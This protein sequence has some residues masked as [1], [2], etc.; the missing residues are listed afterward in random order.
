M[1]IGSIDK[2]TT[3][4]N[5][6]ALQRKMEDKSRS[7]RKSFLSVDTGNIIESSSTSESSE[8]SDSDCENSISR[9]FKQLAPISKFPPKSLPNFA[10]AY[11]RNGVSCRAAAMIVT[12]TLDDT[13]GENANIIDKNK[14]TR[15]KQKSRKQYM[16]STKNAN[17][18][19]LYF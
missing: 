5:E 1:C 11:D 17:V 3:K 12:T 14:V 4:R 18:F 2:T 19:S 15:E 9:K 6:K 16:D 8:D 7:T 10:A 13:E